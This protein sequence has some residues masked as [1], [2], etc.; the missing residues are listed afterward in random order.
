MPESSP[1]VKAK[2]D[3]HGERELLTNSLRAAIARSRLISNTLETISVALRHRQ[4]SCDQALAWLRS[5]NLL[6]H[7][8]LGRGDIAVHAAYRFFEGRDT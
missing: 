4:V 7:I 8:Q 6:D 1:A 2:M 5:E 3:R